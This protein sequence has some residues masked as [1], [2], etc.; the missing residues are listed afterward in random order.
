MCKD[1]PVTTYHIR[2]WGSPLPLEMAAYFTG[3]ANAEAYSPQTQCAGHW[4]GMFVRLI[5][6][7][8][9]QNP[10]TCGSIG[11]LFGNRWKGHLFHCDKKDGY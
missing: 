6:F 3:H 11:L 2:A 1:S 10:M 7:N 5:L 4:E 8:H 9:F